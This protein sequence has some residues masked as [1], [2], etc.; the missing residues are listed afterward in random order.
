MLT[1][2]IPPWEKYNEETK[3]FIYGPAVE[4]RMEHSLVSISKWESI[5]H[6]PFLTDTHKTTTQILSYIKCMTTTQHISDEV[7]QRVSS[8]NAKAIM[9]YIDDP[10]TATWFNTSQKSSNRNVNNEQ[11]TSELIYYW[12]IAYGIPFE[13]QKWHLNRL[14][15]LIKI[16][17]IKN[18]PSKKMNKS[19]IMKRNQ[20]LNAA[21]RN[22]M[23]TRG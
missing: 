18:E 1:I 9:D 10:R 17:Q 5:W 7:Y 21:R 14:L 12:M 13:C 16:C 22:K 20:A 15:T 19:E 23:K 2:I 8:D 4:L 11:I 6:V 3:E